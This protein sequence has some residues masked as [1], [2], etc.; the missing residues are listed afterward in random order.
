MKI[1]FK[2]ATVQ[3]AVFG[4]L[5]GTACS[6]SAPVRADGPPQ[7]PG[8]AGQ[9]DTGPR[10]TSQSQRKSGPQWV[11]S[12]AVGWGTKTCETL[13]RDTYKAECATSC[14]LESG[15]NAAGLLSA[16]NPTTQKIDRTEALSCAQSLAMPN[17]S[18][19]INNVLSGVECCCVLPAKV[20]LEGRANA[21]CSEICRSANVRCGERAG[22]GS[23]FVEPTF[24]PGGEQQSP[25]IRSFT[26]DEKLSLPTDCN[27]KGKPLFSCDCED[28]APP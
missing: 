6:T 18:S 2:T 20:Q 3:I 4:A 23:V 26:C 24:E 14:R 11:S 27:A 5:L 17:L 19:V 25:C 13:C 1:D 28:A 8:D 12:S 10:D 15:G 16:Y 9:G 22:K 21:S 7:G